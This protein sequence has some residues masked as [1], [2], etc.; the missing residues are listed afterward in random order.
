[1]ACWSMGHRIQDSGP[2]SHNV[3]NDLGFGCLILPRQKP[4]R[5]STNFPA[6]S[7]SEHGSIGVRRV[8]RISSL[9]RNIAGRVLDAIPGELCILS[10]RL[11]E[12]DEDV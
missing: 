4:R 1:M 7:R 5:L 3:H 6:L 9:T 12:T 11:I 2:H 10:P 8:P